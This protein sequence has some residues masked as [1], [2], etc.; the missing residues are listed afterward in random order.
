ALGLIV[1]LAGFAF[2]AFGGWVV[3]R[4]PWPNPFVADF[5]ESLVET[6]T[7]PMSL[8][9]TV[10]F[11]YDLRIRKEAFNLA[12]LEANMADLKAR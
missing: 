8:G 7:L 2:E 10:L 4:V 1:T 5:L 9:T 3:G 11:Y 12:L 6:L